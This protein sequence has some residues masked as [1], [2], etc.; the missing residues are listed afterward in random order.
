MTA[1]KVTVVGAYMSTFTRTIRMSLEHFKVPYDQIQALP[2]SEPL[3]KYTP[4]GKIPVL[5]W[6]GQDRPMVETLVMRTYID[7]T[8]A[9]KTEQ[10]PQSLTPVNLEAQLI[11]NFWVS[12]VS[13][14]VFKNLIFGVAKPRE[15]MEKKGSSEQA[16]QERLEKPMVLALQTLTNL[17]DTLAASNYKD[18]PYVC[19]D[20]LTWADLYLYP[21]MADLFSL[22]EADTF[23]KTAPKVWNWYQHFERLDLAKNTYN[24]TVAHQRSSL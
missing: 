7:A 14:H 9:P 15:W 16:I 13:D 17:D 22:P 24:G 5:L 4:F 19:G 1:T 12:V 2:H 18:G 3:K 6:P 23:R 21:C 10:D 8:Y 11:V 20:Q